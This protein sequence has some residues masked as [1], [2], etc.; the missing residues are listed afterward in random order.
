MVDHASMQRPDQQAKECRIP[1][2]SMY[3]T[4]R[5]RL[6]PDQEQKTTLAQKFSMARRAYNTLVA[7]SRETGTAEKNIEKMNDN[8]ATN[9]QLPA[10]GQS[11]DYLADYFLQ[12]E[13][14]HDL[15][16]R[17]ILVS[18]LRHFAQNR[19]MAVQNGRNLHFKSCKQHKQTIRFLVCNQSL[20]I[21]HNT[22][23][24]TLLGQVKVSITRKPVGRLI[25]LTICET[26]AGRY[27]ISLLAKKADSKKSIYKTLQKRKISIVGIDVGITHY[28]TLSDGSTYQNPEFFSSNLT[29]IKRCHRQLSRKNE[30]SRNRAK[31]R[32]RLARKHAQIQNRR[33]G[34]LH[35][36]STEI[37]KKYDVIAIENLSIHQ[38]M[39]QNHRARKIADASW[40]QFM[41]MLS[42]KAKKQGKAV[43]VVPPDL[44]SSKQCCRCH[45]INHALTLQDR[46]WVCSVCQTQHDRDTNAAIN[47]MVA[48]TRIL[49][50]E[51]PLINRAS[52]CPV[53]SE[54]R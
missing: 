13:K 31:A 2:E 18:V 41:W 22:I 43:I 3:L 42:Y 15:T 44:P 53:L 32:L 26:V 39:L 51:W 38:L 30:A 36:V 17:S 40:H 11:Y 24:M 14:S 12:Q 27:Y 10:I 23:R 8:T 16:D 29:S 4:Y 37:V 50:K 49:L 7:W 21:G 1:E 6:Y 9:P 47:I 19:K 54:K 33:N 34:F 20:A 52:L 45:T 46:H 35:E 25:Y 28:L 5:F 48:A